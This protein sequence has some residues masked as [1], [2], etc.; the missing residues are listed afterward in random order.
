M[1]SEAIYDK[2]SCFSNNY[3]LFASSP[4]DGV[5]NSS[6]LRGRPFGGLCILVNKKTFPS[7]SNIS[8]LFSS[9]NFIAVSVDNLLLVNV[10]LPSS[11]SCDD[12]E[13]LLFI[14]GSIVTTIENANFCSVLLGGDLNCNVLIKS[15]LSALI[16]EYFRS[17]GLKPSYD[18]LQESNDKKF[19]F[20]VP[21]RNA[22]S[23]IDFFSI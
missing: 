16:D 1:S 2:L 15:E 6:I 18:F 4:L 12:K 13:K 9:D 17:V 7:C 8:C 22:F 3:F 19:T 11:R 10:Y 21:K 14:L 23:L 20:S 5:I